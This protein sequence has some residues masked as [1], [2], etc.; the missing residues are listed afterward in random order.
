MPKPVAILVALSLIP[1]L[2]RAQTSSEPRNTP[3]NVELR[4]DRIVLA[5]HGQVL[6]DGSIAS[7]SALSFVQL[8]DSS[9]GRLD[10][11]LKW[12]AR[13]GRVTLT[14]TVQGSPEAFAAEAEPREDALRVVRH[15]V[16][17]VANG[18]NRAVYDRRYDWLLSVDFPAR[19]QLEPAKAADSVV[20]YTLTASGG[21]VTLRFRPRFYQRHRGLAQYRPWEYRP[22]TKSVA[23][24]TSWYAFFDRVREADIR[25]TADV[26]SEVL[27]P[28][29]YEYLQID[30]GYQRLPIGPPDHWLEANEKFP[31]GLT[32]LRQYL[33][34]RGL[35][36]GIWTNVSFQDETA[37]AAHPLWFVRTPDSRP[38]RGNW[39]GFVMDGSAA[40][41]LD[42]LVTPVYRAL[43]AMGWTYF[44]LD[45]LRHLR[46]EGYNSYAS[47]Y[48]ERGLD[49]E[50]VF[51]AVVRRVREAIGRDVYL[52]ACWGI[53]P[54]LIGLVDG[55]RVGDDGFG[56]GSFAQYNS[57]NNVVWRN[58]PD[59]IDLHQPDGFRAATLTSLTGSV[60]MLTDRPEV[61]R[62]DRVEAAKRAAPVLFTRPG[63]LYDVDPSRSSLLA[64]AN[65]ELSG[66]GPR[67]FDADQ[68]EVV[69]LYQLDIARPWEQWTVLARTRDDIEAIPLS[70][71]GIAAD[72]AYTA[73]DFWGRR[74]LGV[75]RDTL[76]PGP[77]DPALGVQVI[78][79]RSRSAHPQLVATSRHVTC[80]GPDLR[81]V[82]WRD[83]ILSGESEVVTKDPYVLYVRE[84]A[85]YRFTGATAEGA[86]VVDQRLESGVRAIRLES[87][88]GGPVRWRIRYA[89][90]GSGDENARP[91][92]GTTPS[93]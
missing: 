47:Y 85:G 45:A 53:R 90:A 7:T 8:T 75:V 66:S 6:F 21:E 72:T 80:G 42:T 59:H 52:L 57:F 71:L 56:Y 38:A 11:V 69:S 51:R 15:A 9:G 67:A 39:V 86:R 29:G 28:F 89:A 13:G 35:E 26:L 20:A 46:Y 93:R 16:G 87:E 54:E 36:P 62:T 4:G 79:L 49:R 32:G 48:D 73:F 64:L 33:R 78:C 43:R 12:T 2:V 22:W 24:W 50:A 40:G 88:Q 82:S 30:D 76:R 44:K 17:S 14:G 3:A 18:L 92:P 74:S 70:E 34:E 68:R 23:G 55:I 84:P 81:E 65:T 91:G 31:G 63:Q 58:D 61:Y 10:Q 5:Y 41:A 1:A 25:E 19:V 60:L 37:A 83:G 77:I 27:R